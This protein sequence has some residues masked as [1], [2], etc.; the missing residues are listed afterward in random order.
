MLFLFVCHVSLF[1]MRI[2]HPQPTTVYIGDEK[3]I[4]IRSR[5]CIKLILIIHLSHF[6]CDYYILRIHV[7]LRLFFFGWSQKK[8]R[9]KKKPQKF[10]PYPYHVVPP[11]LK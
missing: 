4:Q 10:N 1:A 9:P 7:F 3:I 11:S 2:I 6:L 8:N 5:G